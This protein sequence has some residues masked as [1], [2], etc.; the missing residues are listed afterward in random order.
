MAKTEFPKCAMH[1]DCFAN[2]PDRGCTALS[3]NKF[4]GRVCPFYRTDIKRIDIER[5]IRHY[6]SMRMKERDTE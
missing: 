3:V 6:T 5:D 2:D 1:P 4:P